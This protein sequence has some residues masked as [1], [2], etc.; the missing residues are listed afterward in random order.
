MATRI[1]ASGNHRGS[2][3]VRSGVRHRSGTRVV[4]ALAAA[5]LL[6]GCGDEPRISADRT[7]PAS[8]S[9]A[10]PTPSDEPTPGSY[11]AFEPSDYTYTLRVTC[12]CLNAG[13]PVSVTVVGGAVTEAVYLE[14][15]SGRGTAR[16]GDPAEE[17]LR[18]TFNDIID[19]ANDPETFRVEV[20]WPPGQDYPTRVRID[21]VERIAD[22]EVG[23]D[24]EGVQVR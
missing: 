24:L 23:Y 7:G 3:D 22:D 15:A 18:L 12:F 19:R 10:T 13:A 14:D 17:Y 6:A 8:G 21:S 4:A 11:R 5:A 20:T 9:S 2:N 16:A 1:T